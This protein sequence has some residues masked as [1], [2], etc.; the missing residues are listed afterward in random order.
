[1]ATV[2][3]TTTIKATPEKVWHVLFTLET[4]QQWTAPFSPASTFEGEWKEGNF[5]HFLGGEGMAMVAKVAE[6]Q[7]HKLMVM[8]HWYALDPEQPIAVMIEKAK[9]KGWHGAEERYELQAQADDTT[10]LTTSTSIS[11]EWVEKMSEM[12][13][14]SL[15]ILVSLC[16]DKKTA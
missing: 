14:E 1:M 8:Q 10:I 9:E 16:E 12:W 6:M 15:T 2:V 4:Y 13:R 3:Q 7:E 11:E 5:V